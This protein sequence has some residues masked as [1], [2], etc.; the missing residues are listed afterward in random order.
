MDQKGNHKGNYEILKDKLKW[1]HSI[2][3]LMGHS[4]SSAKGEM[5]D[6]EHLHEK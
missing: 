4:K 5:C 6:Y 2:P 1:T 3:K